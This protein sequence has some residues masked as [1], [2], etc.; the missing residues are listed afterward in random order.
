M[1]K[2]KIKNELELMFIKDYAPNSLPLTVNSHRVLFVKRLPNF[3][4]SDNSGKIRRFFI[5][6][7]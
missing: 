2:M 5:I 4:K 3:S 7:I 6:I 1:P